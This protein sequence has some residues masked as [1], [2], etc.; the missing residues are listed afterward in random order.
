[1]TLGKRLIMF[2]QMLEYTGL[3][4]GSRRKMMED[5]KLTFASMVVF[6][7]LVLISLTPT[8]Q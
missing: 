4:G 7:A 3:F 2:C 1:M 8:P 6:S 5:T